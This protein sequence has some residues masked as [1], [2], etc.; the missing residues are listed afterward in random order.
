M[1]HTFHAGQ[2]VRFRN[3]VGTTVGHVVRQTKEW[4]AVE[5]VALI[6]KAGER[7]EVATVGHFAPAKL[8]AALA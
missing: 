7:I 2:V 8:A 1:T 6:T 4:V 5:I 3:G